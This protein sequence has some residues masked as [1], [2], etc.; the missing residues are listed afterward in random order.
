MA[1]AEK[2]PANINRSQRVLA[3]MFASTIGLS[4][5][6]IFVILAAGGAGVN[7]AEGAWPVVMLLPMIGLPLGFIL[8]IA[9]VVSTSV[10]RSRAA[11][12]DGN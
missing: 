2:T 10:S 12:D 7:L 11:K 6:A 1:V 3:Y 9:L 5:I 4:L 8:V